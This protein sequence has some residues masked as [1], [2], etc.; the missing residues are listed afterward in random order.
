MKKNIFYLL[1]FSSLILNSCSSEDDI[2]Y[3]EDFEKSKK[4]WLKFKEHFGNSYEYTVKKGS[5]AWDGYNQETT[6]K[7]VG[8]KVVQRRFKYV[9]RIENVPKE[10]LLEWTEN[11]NE[12]NTHNQGASP[13]TLDEIYEKAEKEWLIKRENVS[14][15]F[16][17]K[18]DGLISSC[19]YVPEG[20][21]DDCFRGIHIKEIKGLLPIISN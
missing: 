5:W 8:G 7:V 4:A 2:N 17:A 19:G 15:Y 12:I 18:N 16:E 13:L 21:M 6:I 9:G 10:E 14:T 3:S 20:C 11:E 1:I